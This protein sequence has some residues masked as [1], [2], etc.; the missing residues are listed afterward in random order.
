MASI[1]KLS[2]PILEELFDNG[3]G[4]RMALWKR[5]D[6]VGWEGFKRVLSMLVAQGM[7]EHIDDE[8]LEDRL[9]LD[10]TEEGHELIASLR[11]TDDSPVV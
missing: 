3:P 5:C 9:L 11:A 1:K 10:L 7:I 8:D 2:F 4:Q 6:H